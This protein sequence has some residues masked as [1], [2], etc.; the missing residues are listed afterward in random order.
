M[1]SFFS[2][3]TNVLKC[4]LFTLRIELIGAVEDPADSWLRLGSVIMV[5]MW[6]LTFDGSMEVMTSSK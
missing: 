1:Q 4:L 5:D 3:L 2:N 6:S